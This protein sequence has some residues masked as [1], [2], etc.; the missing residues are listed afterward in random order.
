[1][2]LAH[3]GKR[4]SVVAVSTEQR[5]VEFMKPL[6]GDMSE[7]TIMRQKEKLGLSLEPDLKPDD[8]MKIVKSVVSLCRAMAGDSI[9][10]KMEEGLTKIVKESVDT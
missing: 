8:Y 5:M 3:V 2:R 7:R 4:D 9:A 1:M 10:R 6:F